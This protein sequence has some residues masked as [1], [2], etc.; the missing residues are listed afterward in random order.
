MF[1]YLLKFKKNVHFPLLISFIITLYLT[2][3][4]LIHINS[5][6]S[7][8]IVKLFSFVIQNFPNLKVIILVIQVVH[9]HPTF[10]DVGMALYILM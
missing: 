1:V 8:A 6:I 3:N 5:K 7:G 10:C 4:A 9:R 2:L